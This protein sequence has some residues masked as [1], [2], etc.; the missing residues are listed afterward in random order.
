[1]KNPLDQYFRKNPAMS[2]AELARQTGA[3]KTMITLICQG[4]RRPST[5]LAA[6]IANA[7]DRSDMIAFWYPELAAA[8]TDP[9]PTPSEERV[10]G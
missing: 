8:L 4:K 2:R 10:N 1:M 7:T 3:S 6:E 5:E 9:T